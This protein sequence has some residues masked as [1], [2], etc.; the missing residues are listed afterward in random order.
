VLTRSFSRSLF[1]LSGFGVEGADAALPP[2]PPSEN[3]RGG[4]ALARRGEEIGGLWGNGGDR[5][6]RRR[7]GRERGRRNELQGGIRG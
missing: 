2:P 6:A 3:S 1:A 7:W 4:I 5:A